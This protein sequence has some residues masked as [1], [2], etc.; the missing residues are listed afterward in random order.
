M[1]SRGKT[2]ARKIANRAQKR[3][4][5]TSTRGE[6]GLFL[7]CLLGHLITNNVWPRTCLATDQ[8]KPELNA[9]F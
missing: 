1:K 8:L 7:A 3:G 2:G 4:A 9:Y 6:A 5:N